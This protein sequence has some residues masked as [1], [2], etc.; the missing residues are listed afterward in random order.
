MAKQTTN[1]TRRSKVN[2]KPVSVKKSVST[3]SSTK[4]KTSQSKS[5]KRQPVKKENVA[6]EPEEVVEE[7]VEDVVEEVVEEVVEDEPV[8]R[9]TRRV[10]TRENLV[11]DG[12]E[13]VDMINDEISRLRTSESKAKGVKYLRSL[14]KKVKAYNTNVVRLTKQR[15]RAK[16]E[17]SNNS[18]FLK[19]VQISSELCDFTGWDHAELKSRVDVTKYICKYIKENDLQNPADRREIFADDKLCDLLNYERERDGELKYYHVQK[20]L[21]PHFIKTSNSSV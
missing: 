16:R 1:Q 17:N 12:Q 5:R 19:P 8:V 21:K 6:P 14:G 4:A 2:T 13:I 10:V 3:K 20:F 11:V 15:T 7:V 18:G 9:K